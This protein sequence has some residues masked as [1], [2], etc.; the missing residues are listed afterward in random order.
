MQIKEIKARSGIE[1][2]LNNA[3]TRK[4]LETLGKC[5]GIKRRFFESNGKY[6][7]RLLRMLK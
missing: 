2:K 4:E 5:Y 7:S 3:I 1:E 6:E